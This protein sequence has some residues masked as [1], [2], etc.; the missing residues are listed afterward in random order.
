MTE[1]VEARVEEQVAVETSE[2]TTEGKPYQRCRLREHY[3]CIDTHVSLDK[4]D[5]V[6]VIDTRRDPMWL[7]RHCVHQH[8]VGGLLDGQV[9]R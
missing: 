7:V 1:R 4:S 8:K 9:I 3:T 2:K 5:L 6:D